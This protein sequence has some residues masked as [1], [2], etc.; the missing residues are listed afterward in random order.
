MSEDRVQSAEEPPVESRPPPA[1]NGRPI[2]VDP[3]LDFIRAVVDQ[4]GP[5]FKRCFQCGTCSSTCEL[6]PTEDPFP[7]KEMSWAGWGM[8]A[9]LK[10]D[11]DVWLCHQCNDCTTNCP[12]GGRPGDVLAAVRME[13]ILTYSWPRFLAAWARKPS[14]APLLIF[15][16]A[17]LLAL[18]VWFEP[19]IL[20]ALGLALEAGQPVS[21][22]YSAPL[23]HGL[24]NLLFGTAFLIVIVLTSIGARRFWRGLKEG[25]PPDRWGKNQL[26]KSIGKTIANV[27]LHRDFTQCSKAANRYFAHTMLFYGFIA[28]TVVTIVTIT[29]R[30]NPLVTGEFLYPFHF[31]SPWKILANLGGI[32]V[33]AGCFLMIRDRFV[34]HEGAGR[35]TWFDWSL[36]WL[37]MFVALSGFAV[38]ALHYM[39]LEPH[40][41]AAYFVHLLL[42]LT[43]FLYLPY[44]KFAHVVYRF[45][46]LVFIEWTGRREA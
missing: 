16:P 35:S 15:F 34:E 11:A 23:P 39:R 29:H 25:V 27:M 28:L 6:S 43:L 41:H 7:R 14:Y 8:A 45:V 1:S 42:I 30:F 24:I 26:G 2:V 21:Y 5:T 19:E 12:R 4:A 46:A 40:R 38:E 32:G 22:P 31:F 37:I 9:K 10:R 13:Q 20:A 17:A 3:D 18:A 36:L 33:V 44:S